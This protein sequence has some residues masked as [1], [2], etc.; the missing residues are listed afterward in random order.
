MHR[1]Y[2]GVY[3]VSHAHLTQEAR[4]L[5]AVRACGPDAVLSHFAAAALRELV[6][7]DGR[8]I[9]VTAPGRHR[10]PRVRA[11]RSLHVEREWVHGIRV[12]PKLRTVVSGMTI[13]SRGAMTRSAKPS[14]KLA[15]SA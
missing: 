12:T 9:D 11:H 14:S 2:R 8:P 6:R 5:A 10:H 1:L 7:W 15:A 4:W 13:R 3:A